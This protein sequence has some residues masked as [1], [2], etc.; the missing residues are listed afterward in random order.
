VVDWLR[1]GH[2]PGV[3]W[4]GE[5]GSAAELAAQGY[6]AFLEAVARDSRDVEGIASAFAA[7]R[8][9]CAVRGGPEGVDALNRDLAVRARASL[10][11]DGAGEWYAGRPVMVRVNDYALRLFNGDI[12]I[13]LPDADGRLV[14]WF[15]ESQGWRPILPARMPEHE[16][17]YAM[18]V[19]K[20][21]GSEFGRVLVV[22]PPADSPVLTRE[23]LYTAV[24]RAREGVRLHGGEAALRAAIGRPTQRHSGLLDRIREAAAA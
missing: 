10:P 5:A 2:D 16:T 1:A 13:A 8:V 15:Q 18:T 9:L 20:S 17:A 23:L 21:Q 4:E 14:V 11:S 24:T 3:L 22:L 7:F 12:G 6:A 19:H